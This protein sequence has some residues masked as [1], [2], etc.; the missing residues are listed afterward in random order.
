[1]TL[2]GK[3]GALKTQRDP[4]IV[5][6]GLKSRRLLSPSND[7]MAAPSKK[8]R[9]MRTNTEVVYN[10]TGPAGQNRASV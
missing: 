4:A 9:N 6:L 7:V 10:T 1:M 8:G 3:P 5:D 2:I